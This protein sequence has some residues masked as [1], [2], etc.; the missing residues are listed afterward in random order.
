M[1][2]LGLIMVVLFLVGGGAVISQL[3]P[4]TITYNVPATPTPTPDL[5]DR[6][7][8]DKLEELVG[9]A[10]GEYGVYVL[11]IGNGEEY[12]IN[13]NEKFDAASFFKL[14][15]HILALRL[16]KSG[17]WSLDDEFVIKASDIATG[18]GPLQFSKSGT[19]V[20][21][22]RMLTVLGKNSDN[23]AWRMLNRLI[24]VP[25]IQELIDELEAGNSDYKELLTTPYDMG[26]IWWHI[27]EN[28]LGWEYLVDSIYEDR[29]AVGIPEGTRLIHKVGTDVGVWSDGGVVDDKFILVIMTSDAAAEEAKKL[30]PDITKKIWEY[31]ISRR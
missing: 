28:K 9:E 26:I 12:G 8:E 10:K 5:R 19:K 22:E 21:L 13:I 18:S 4:T 15:A 23:T 31:E 6:E 2:K 30:V 20:T 1:K 25:N 3:K 29:I 11:R 24:G 27:Y 16:V 17:E 14:P 7:F